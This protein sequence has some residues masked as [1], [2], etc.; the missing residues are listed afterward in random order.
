MICNVMLY[1]YLFQKRFDHFCDNFL[2]S[3]IRVSPAT[4]AVTNVA[5]VQQQRSFDEG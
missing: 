2:V 4:A 3:V 5:Q 1:V